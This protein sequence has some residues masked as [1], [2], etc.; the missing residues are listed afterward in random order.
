MHYRPHFTMRDLERVLAQ[1]LP[2]D[3]AFGVATSGYQAEGG[4]NGPDEPKNNWYPHEQSGRV[5][6]TGGA[7]RL[8]EL[9][10]ED[11][12]RAAALGCRAFRLGIEWARVQPAVDPQQRGPADFDPAALDLYAE[13]LHGI[14]EAGMEPH[15]TLFHFV[16]PLWAGEDLWLHRDLCVPLFAQ[17][18][19]ETIERL[20]T[21]LIERGSAPLQRII[22]INEPLMVPFA[23]YVLKHFPGPS[24]DRGFGTAI[25]ALENN[26][27]AHVEAVERLRGLYCERGW[28]RPLISTN[29]WSCCVYE[30]DRLPC[31]LLRAPA[32]G[33]GP[34]ELDAYIGGLRQR[35]IQRMLDAPLSRSW[36]GVRRHFERR[37]QWWVTKLMGPRPFGALRDR[38]LRSDEPLI[39]EVLLDY[40]DPFM[41]DYVDLG[42]RPQLRTEPWDWRFAPE[43]MGP[44][45]EGYADGAADAPIGIVENGMGL[46]HDGVRAHARRDGVQRDQALACSLYEVAKAVRAGIKIDRY[47]YWTLVDNYEWG[48]Y[49]PR[50]GLY[51]VD[52]ANGAQ[53]METD[54][55]GVDAGRAYTELIEALQ[56][57]GREAVQ[58]FARRSGL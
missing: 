56:S 25:T 48:S 3:F 29:S 12:Q 8:L 45:L 23:T 21:R 27:L 5:Q 57:G 51:G 20:N 55:A 44:I 19:C 22:T 46:R 28:E 58:V 14:R 31:D 54:A 11:V 2:V 39:D 34:R 47:Y 18:A 1:P 40:Y 35:H 33:V 13:I 52:Y 10:R 50:F 16:H 32:A 42:L 24:A 49:E 17:Y 26:Y 53:R 9:W 7:C 37:L 41:L 36:P 43:G 38:V 30:L 15:P 6:R 4:F